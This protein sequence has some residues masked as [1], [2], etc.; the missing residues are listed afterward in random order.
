MSGLAVK[1]SKPSQLDNELIQ[2]LLTQLWAPSSY[3]YLTSTW[4]RSR[5]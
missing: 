4:H 1:H 5:D 2:D 3:L